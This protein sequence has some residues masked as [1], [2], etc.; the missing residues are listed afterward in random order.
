MQKAKDAQEDVWHAKLEQII[1]ESALQLEE[2]INPKI[3]KILQSNL[4][5]VILPELSKIIAS[6]IASIRHE[7]I[8]QCQHEVALLTDRL[9][10]KCRCHQDH[11]DHQDHQNHQNYYHQDHHDY[12][13]EHQHAQEPFVLGTALKSELATCFV[14]E[15]VPRVE[16][17]LQNM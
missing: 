16:N 17:A 15:L 2:N 13:K 14:Q 9:E 7:L 8:E 12:Q 10:S 11:Q 1:K 3:R 4:N 5:H 6:S